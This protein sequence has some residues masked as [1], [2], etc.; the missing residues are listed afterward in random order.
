MSEFVADILKGGLFRRL[1]PDSA[2]QIRGFAVHRAELASDMA[3]RWRNRQHVE[4]F[5]AH[6]DATAGGMAPFSSLRWLLVGYVPSDQWQI[7][8]KAGAFQNV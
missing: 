7:G 1:R 4:L 8:P 6:F 3:D 2:G 5:R